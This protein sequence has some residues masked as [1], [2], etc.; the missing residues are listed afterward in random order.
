MRSGLR[1][2]YHA[3]K[4]GKGDTGVKN[5]R[6]WDDQGTQLVVIHVGHD[7]QSNVGE[8]TS[9]GT[10]RVP[11]ADRQKGVSDARWLGRGEDWCDRLCK[12]GHPPIVGLHDPNPPAEGGV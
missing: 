10:P 12:A 2:T 11:G 4:E 3:R 1:G 6:V 7:V 8:A 9:L 5:T